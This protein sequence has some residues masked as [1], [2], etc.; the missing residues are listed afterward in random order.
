MQHRYAI[1]DASDEPH[2][3]LYHQHCAAPADALDDVGSPRGL[4]IAHTRHWLIQKDQSRVGGKHHP[5]LNPLTLPMRQ[6]HDVSR[7]NRLE[8]KCSQERITGDLY[9][10]RISRSSGGDP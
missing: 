8:L 4:R 2:I 7:S 6:L 10:L 5:Q 9:I 1:R 3:V